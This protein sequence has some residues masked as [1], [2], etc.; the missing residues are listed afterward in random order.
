MFDIFYIISYWFSIFKNTRIVKIKKS[1]TNS[2]LCKI[3]IKLLFKP[4]YTSPFTFGKHFVKGEMFDIFYIILY[5]FSIF[6]IQLILKIK[7]SRTY[8]KLCK[9]IVTLLLN[10][11]IL[12]LLQIVSI[13]K[14]GMLD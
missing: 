4:I 7:K 5:W 12:S 9:I 1:R 8:S 3:I 14:R 6:K 2:K 10:Q 13:C 11:T